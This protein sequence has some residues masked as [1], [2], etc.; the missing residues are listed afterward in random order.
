MRI[1]SSVRRVVVSVIA[2]ALP[3]AAAAQL[4][5]GS[6]SASAATSSV[7][8]VT[9]AQTGQTTAVP[10]DGLILK[11]RESGGLT[12]DSVGAGV[13]VRIQG[14][15]GGTSNCTND[16]TSKTLTT[17]SG[18]VEE[19]ISFDAKSSGSCAFEKSFSYF[20]I[21]VTGRNTSGTAYDS[22]IRVR[23]GQP[24]PR[25]AYSTSCVTGSDRRMSCRETS[26]RAVDLRAFPETLR[27]LGSTQSTVMNLTGVEAGPQVT[28]RGGGAGTSNCTTDETSTSFTAKGGT[29]VQCWALRPRA[30]AAVRS[31]EA[32]ANSGS[33]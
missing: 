7:S 27:A 23:L 17:G 32:S 29:I 13:S 18:P 33:P 14:G 31:K 8:S 6:A 26:M 3:V 10:R 30:A 25:G 9:A 1:K 24:W 16:E 4:T 19:T 15:G 12:L 21:S 20:T 28:I 11:G 22:V 5:L 2:G